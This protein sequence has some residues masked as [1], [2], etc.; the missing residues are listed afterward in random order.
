MNRGS[1]NEVLQQELIGRPPVLV[2][3]GGEDYPLAFPIYAVILYKQETA[4]LNRSRGSGRPKPT[5]SEV[6]ESTQRFSDLLKE[7]AALDGNSVDGVGKFRQVMEEATLVKLPIDEATGNGDSLCLM[8]N[9]YR[10]TLDDPE[11]IVLALWA[12]LHTRQPDKS[13]KPRFE[14]SE[15]QDEKLFNMSNAGSF[16]EPISQALIAHI[17]RD[18]ES[19]PSPNVP[20]PAA[21]TP[22]ANSEN[23]PSEI[24]GPLPVLTSV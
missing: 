21:Q 22:P 18:E 14:L 8:H 16:I 7:A 5:P 17:K 11:R 24:S 6:R 23:L 19:D 9:W 3:L 2:S 10:I 1:Q 13:W 20:A 12:G 4:K 15:L